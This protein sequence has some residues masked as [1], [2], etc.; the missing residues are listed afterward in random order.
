MSKL[1]QKQAR[2]HTAGMRRAW[3]VVG[4]IALPV[5]LLIGAMAI[6][7]GP[8]EPTAAERAA[9]REQV[10]AVSRV[11]TDAGATL[12]ETKAG[13]FVIEIPLNQAMTMTERQAKEMALAAYQRLGQ[14]VSVKSPA[15]QVLA[16]AP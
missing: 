16:E 2:T 3:I 15:G 7:G 12:R 5:V 4:L 10:A 11:I 14:S 8:K 6:S 1:S 9:R 13:N